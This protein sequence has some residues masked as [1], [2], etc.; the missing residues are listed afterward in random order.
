MGI[1]GKSRADNEGKQLSRGF[2]PG[3]QVVHQTEPGAWTSWEGLLEKTTKWDQG[4]TD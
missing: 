4:S 3:F 1:L 2:H